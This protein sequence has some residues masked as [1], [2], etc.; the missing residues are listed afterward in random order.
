[1]NSSGSAVQRVI[2]RR[3]F[4]CFDIILADS[5]DVQEDILAVSKRLAP[6]IVICSV[7]LDF[8]YVRELANGRSSV[9]L[10]IPKDRVIAIY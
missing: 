7:G 2:Y 8:E 10:A 1:M 5:L 6:K 9:E 4:S 3:L